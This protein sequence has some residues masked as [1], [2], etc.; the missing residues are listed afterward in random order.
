[1]RWRFLFVAVV[2]AFPGL[3]EARPHGA[4]HRNHANAQ[5]AKSRRL[6]ADARPGQARRDPFRV[7]PREVSVPRPDAGRSIPVARERGYR[8]TRNVGTEADP[9]WK[10]EIEGW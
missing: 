10:V 9:I 2:L 8:G 5:R 1:M 4:T 7:A 6:R 3:S